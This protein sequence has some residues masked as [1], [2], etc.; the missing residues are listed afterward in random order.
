M[1]T[2]IISNMSVPMPIKWRDCDVRGWRP[3]T[4]EGATLTV[5][6]ISKLPGGV[7]EEKA[8]L[9]GGLSR[10]LHSTVACLTN[11]NYKSRLK[12]CYHNI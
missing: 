4:R 9:F 1:L 8:Y 11:D 10:D 12:Y 7:E 2:N 6:S 5:V 3:E